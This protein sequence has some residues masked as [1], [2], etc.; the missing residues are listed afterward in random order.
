MAEPLYLKDSYLKEFEATVIDVREFEGNIL[1]VLDRTAFYPIG[2][3]Q[4]Y[5]TGRIIN[6]EGEEY[7]VKEVYKYKGEI[8]HVVDR[9]GLR[10]GDKV[11]GI[12]N[13][14]RRY[15]LMRMHT[16]AHLISALMGN[17]E[18]VLITGN[19]LGVEKSRIDFNLET[20]DREK[21][22]G[23]VEKANKLIEEG[24]EV[25]TYFLPREEALKIPTISRLAKGLPGDLKEIRIVEIEGIDK[26]ADGG[27]HV[28]NIKE[29]GRIEL[30][31]IENKGRNNRRLY[32]TLT[33]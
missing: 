14:D 23:Y 19:Q 6:E 20:L 31:K 33:E 25:K 27:T 4:P 26:Q 18:G 2:G 15:R 3:G 9:E 11:K 24:R 7:I 10:V 13:W 17:E 28:K 12:I 32:F 16:A 8:F 30:L 29:I 5:D 22:R 21:I 1:I